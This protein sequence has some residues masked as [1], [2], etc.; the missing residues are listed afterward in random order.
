MRQ[1]HIYLFQLHLC[2][3]PRTRKG[4]DLKFHFHK[5]F[6]DGFNPRTRKGCD[7]NM[8][9]ACREYLV[10]IHAPVKDATSNIKCLP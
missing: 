7:E 9:K 2:F 6:I 1:I 4:C 8:G 3:N 10:S 5:I